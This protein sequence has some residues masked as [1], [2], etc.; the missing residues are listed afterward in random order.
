MEA[1]KKLIK[2]HKVNYSKNFENHQRRCKKYGLNFF[3]PSEK[4]INL[5]TM[6]WGLNSE[7]LKPTEIVAVSLS[8][9][10]N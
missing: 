1:S 2:Y 9:Q 5:L 6:K 3:V 7:I 10:S 4:N 8:R